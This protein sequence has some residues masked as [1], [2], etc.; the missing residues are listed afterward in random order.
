M[1]GVMQ[2]ERSWGAGSSPP[3]AGSAQGHLCTANCACGL[4]REGWAG[5]G[6]KP[7]TSLGLCSLTYKVRIRLW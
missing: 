7:G 2:L 1:S 4:S 6:W 5:L 3:L